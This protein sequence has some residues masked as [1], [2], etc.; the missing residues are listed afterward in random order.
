VCVP[1]NQK[2]L[3]LDTLQALGENA[4]AV[5]MVEAADDKSASASVRYAPGLLAS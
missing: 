1:A 4:W 2:E 5:G 3:A